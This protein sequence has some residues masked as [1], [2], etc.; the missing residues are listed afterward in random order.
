MKN[1]IHW[2]PINPVDDNTG[3]MTKA[4]LWIVDVAVP[5]YTKQPTIIT[6]KT[7]KT[8]LQK[9][10]T[11]GL[12][13]DEGDTLYLLTHAI[14]ED[15]NPNN[16][17]IWNIDIN[18][19][20]A[21]CSIWILEY[22]K[23]WNEWDWN[24]E[25]TEE[26]V[27]V[28]YELAMANKDEHEDGEGDDT[29]TDEDLEAE[30]IAKQDLSKELNVIDAPEQVEKMLRET[31]KEHQST[32][33]K[34]KKCNKTHYFVWTG[35]H[36][37]DWKEFYWNFLIRFPEFNEFQKDNLDISILNIKNP[38]L[39]AAIEC[40]KKTDQELYKTLIENIKSNQNFLES[41]DISK[42]EKLVIKNNIIKIQKDINRL[43]VVAF[44]NELRKVLWIRHK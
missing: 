44:S 37:V 14:D 35:K 28:D 36:E 40:L 21:H 11:A 32:N 27:I 20:L 18:A 15:L 8:V 43:L 25:L 33:C 24:V 2:A 31:L 29:N 4:E 12:D 10:K 5:F 42:D 1:N 17:Q 38:W 30:R 22:N 39:D 34:K 3:E 26:A 23:E 9:L 13:I 7:K 6:G 19:I 41:W 16:R